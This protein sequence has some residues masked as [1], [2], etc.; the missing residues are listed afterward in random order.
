MDQAGGEAATGIR[1]R[2]GRDTATISRWLP[3]I[4]ADGLRNLLEWKKALVRRW[5]FR[6]DLAQLEAQS[7]QTP[8][9]SGAGE[10]VEWLK[11]RFGKTL[12]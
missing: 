9:G 10:I 12:K 3:E 11:Q 8:K 5:K 2:L 4:S 6:G 7:Q 1:Q